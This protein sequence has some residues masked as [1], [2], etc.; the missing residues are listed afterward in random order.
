[1][2]IFNDLI[3]ILACKEDKKTRGQET[4]AASCGEA[5][6]ENIVVI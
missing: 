4:R 6:L 3:I 1:M 2:Y 5:A